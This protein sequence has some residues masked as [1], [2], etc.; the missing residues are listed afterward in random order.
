MKNENIIL[1]NLRS[2][3]ILPWKCYNTACNPF[4]ESIVTWTW[5]NLYKG[6]K[7]IL[8]IELH[9]RD[10]SWYEMVWGDMICI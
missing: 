6:K 3:T 9:Q 7:T 1:K 8:I 2:A 5:T 10:V 4:V